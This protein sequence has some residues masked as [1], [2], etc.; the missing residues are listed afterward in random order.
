MLDKDTLK[1]MI[2][3]RLRLDLLCC[4]V[5]YLFDIL[6]EVIHSVL[7]WVTHLEVT[8]KNMVSF[9]VDIVIWIILQLLYDLHSPI[10][11][12]FLNHQVGY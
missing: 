1:C 2:S 6:F 4:R 10:S 3:R 9:L 12:Q 11:D 5:Y 8:R 7:S